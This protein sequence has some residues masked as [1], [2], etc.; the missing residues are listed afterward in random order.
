MYFC[1]VM[2]QDCVSCFNNEDVESAVGEA[3]LEA[4]VEVYSGYILAEWD[5]VSAG[6]GER[7]ELT[8]VSFTSDNQ[9]LTI[10]CL[11]TN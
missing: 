9:P 3:L 2:G 5:T 4:G 6:D 7:A 1:A 8:A 11:V 10:N